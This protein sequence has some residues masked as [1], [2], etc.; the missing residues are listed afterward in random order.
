VV[1]EDLIDDG[2]SIAEEPEQIPIKLQGSWAQCKVKDKNIL[3]LVKEGTSPPRQNPNG[4]QTL[5]LK[6]QP[7]T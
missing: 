3:A 7:L 6:C 1:E 2:G 4:G 5:R